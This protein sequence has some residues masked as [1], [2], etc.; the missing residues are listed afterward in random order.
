MCA[1]FEFIIFLCPMTS[2]RRLSKFTLNF[3][4]LIVGC[5]FTLHNFPVRF[6]CMS[7]L[8]PFALIRCRSVCPRDGDGK[9]H[10]SSA[11]LRLHVRFRRL[12]RGTRPSR[13]RPLSANFRRAASQYVSGVR[14]R[15]TP[16]AIKKRHCVT[17][18]TG[19]ACARGAGIR[20]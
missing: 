16:T 11:N 18:R 3:V 15:R 1:G 12:R 20:R 17:L 9:A 19:T 7:I 14:A 5:F 4:F 2:P 10:T 8:V 13:S 6:G